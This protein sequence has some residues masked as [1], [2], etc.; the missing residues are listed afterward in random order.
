MNIEIE[1]MDLNGNTLPIHKQIK[2]QGHLFLLRLNDINLSINDE[3]IKWF[4]VIQDF[5]EKNDELIF[6]MNQIRAF[7]NEE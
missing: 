3:N 2:K 7:D 4:M 1:Q 5:E 6:D